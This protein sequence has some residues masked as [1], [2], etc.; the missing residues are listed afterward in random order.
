MKRFYLLP[1]AAALVAVFFLY[2]SLNAAEPVGEKGKT[3][4]A[5]PVTRPAPKPLS[6]QVNKGLAWLAKNQLDDGSWGQGDESVHMGGGKS[7]ASQP[8]VAD[9]C[10]GA[11][12][13]YRS[14]S[15]PREGPYKDH[16]FKAVK[17]VCT[18]VEGSDD[19]S[20]FITSLRNTRTQQK[21]GTYI[22]T[23]LAAQMLSELKNQM[24]NDDFTKRVEAALSKIARKIEINQKDDG[25]WANEGWAPTIA[26]GQAAK[27]LNVMAQSGVKVDEQVRQK[28]ES[29][30][31]KDYSESK[32]AGAGGFARAGSAGVE[33][34]TRGSQLAAMNASAVTN[35]E[36]R[37][38]AEQTLNSPTTRPEEKAQAKKEI[39]RID[40]AQ[41]SLNEAA[42]EVV[43]RM[44]DK[45]FVAGFGSNGGEEFLSYLNI[46]ETLFLKGGEDWTKWDGKMTENLN[47][48]QNGDGS[49]S[50]HHCITGRTFCTSAALMVLTIDRAPAPA[51]IVKK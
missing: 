47:R 48:V 15:T 27:A 30:A 38:Q 25:R 20:L 29:Y 18:S 42:K 51:K 32:A 37:K 45:Q 9:T 7:L 16:L 24:P 36:L 13:L 14:G 12:A 49:W 3:P 41:Q 11:M 23:F 4:A 34:Y 28:A 6:D 5:S 33:L 44:D 8:N 40:S 10:M 46:G 43:G 17:F 39:E 50:G 31:L 22:D 19:K 21:L 2:A 1:A 26:Q 35:A